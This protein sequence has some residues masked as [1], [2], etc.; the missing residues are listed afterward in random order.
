[1]LRETLRKDLSEGNSYLHSVKIQE[2]ESIIYEGLVVQVR[3]IVL[4]LARGRI[5][6]DLL[7]EIAN[8]AIHR[9][10]NAYVNFKGNSSLKTYFASIVRNLTID[11]IK[12]MSKER[13]LF[14]Q[15]DDDLTYAADAQAV[16]AFSA[17][18]KAAGREDPVPEFGDIFEIIDWQSQ[19]LTD[20][21]FVAVI[22]KLA[23]LR[24]KKKLT[25]EEL[26]RKLGM[27]R[28]TFL[29]TFKRGRDKICLYWKEKS[30]P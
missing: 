21:E 1:K 10:F 2:V 8:E 29:D 13:H 14:V 23:A 16:E 9:M 11:H 28:S 24:M 26:A 20:K 25:D 6:E 3:T 15:A 30:Q 5:P 27:K 19:N 7:T 22:L 4:G 12:K 18:A 17:E